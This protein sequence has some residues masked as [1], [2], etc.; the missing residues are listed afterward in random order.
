MTYENWNSLATC[1]KKLRIAEKTKR[2]LVGVSLWDHI[3]IE[4]LRERIRVIDV[5]YFKAK[6]NW[7]EHVV[8]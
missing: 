8:R 5:A 6:W 1:A 2:L 4:D 3:R 7:A